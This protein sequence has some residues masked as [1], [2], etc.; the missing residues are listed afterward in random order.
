MSRL[1]ALRARLAADT[2]GGQPTAAGVWYLLV[3]AGV[4]VA[5]VNTGNNLIYAVLAAQLSVLLVNNVLAEWNLRALE[6]RRVLPGELFAE[7]PATGRFVLHNPR[8]LGAAWRVEVEERE[9][10][11]AR[12]IFGRVGPGEG[13]EE[14]AS[15]TFALRGPVRLGTLRVG[16]RFPFGLVHRWRDV[17]VG[18]EVLVYP[19]PERGG[20][21]ELSTGTGEGHPDRTAR[22]ASGDFAGLRAYR[23]G[24][25]V[26]RIHWPTS[27]RAGQPYV[28]LRSGE[29]GA[30][31]VLRVDPR[32]GERGIRRA[33]GQA[34][35]HLKRGD[36]VGLHA[37]D[38]RVPPRVG[39][40]QRRRLLTTLALLP[41]EGRAPTWDSSPAP[42][43]HPASSGGAA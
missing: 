6:V 24:D 22:D 35:F 5:A 36:A 37:G 30:E 29:R 4:L 21:G 13:A 31:V 17:R 33:C 42:A 1:G 14:F 43:P 8:L 25:P 3:V 7:T 32:D 15:W 2:N 23:P 20:P 19:A 27:A 12:A 28:A 11:G 41:G 34:L 18:G 40:T 9:G 39:P 38:Q 10:G 16:S 26:R